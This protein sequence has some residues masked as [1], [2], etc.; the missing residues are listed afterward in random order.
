MIHDHAMM[1]HYEK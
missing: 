1:N